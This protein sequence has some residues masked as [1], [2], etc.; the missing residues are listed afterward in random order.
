VPTPRERPSDVRIGPVRYAITWE[1]EAIKSAS[2]SADDRGDTGSNGEWIA[3]SDHEKMVIGLNPDHS[4]EYNRISLV[5]EVLHCCLRIAGVWPNTYGRILAE[6]RDRDEGV[7][8]EEFT[9][10]AQAP[11]LLGVLRDNPGVLAWLTD[12]PPL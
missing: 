1:S 2:D 4:D 11:T 7:P 8:V 9:I 10:S 6:A 12:T 3:Y 5:H